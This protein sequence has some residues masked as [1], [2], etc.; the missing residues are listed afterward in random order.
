M[1]HFRKIVG[2]LVAIAVVLL[3][4]GCGGSDD[5]SSASTETISRAPTKAVFIKQADA[6]CKKAEGKRQA[7]I[8]A[9]LAQ[10][11][12]DPQQP[13]STESRK[14][15][16]LTVVLPPL[17]DTAEH[18]RAL[19]VP[20]ERQATKVIEEFEKASDRYEDGAVKGRQEAVDPFTKVSR[21][22]YEYGFKACI[23]AL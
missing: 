13:L 5:S 1:H 21:Q 2:T 4:V 17:R 7:G 18:L 6:F 8:Q 23:L 20:N 19:A 3:A 22:A 14:E 10:S 9:F 12:L 11:G 16:A 15:M